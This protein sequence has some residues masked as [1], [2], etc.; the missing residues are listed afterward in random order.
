[1]RRGTYYACMKQVG[2]GTVGTVV[3]RSSHHSAPAGCHH[4]ERR[5]H[6]P[7]FKKTLKLGHFI[8]KI[9]DFLDVN[10]QFTQFKHMMRAP[11]KT[12][13]Y[14]NHAG[15]LDIIYFIEFL[16]VDHLAF[17]IPSLPISFQAKFH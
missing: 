9:S 8:F 1:M 17:K 6:G 15:N 10:D 13:T 5:P 2:R 16:K 14:K 11:N 4:L 7:I 3:R 12:K